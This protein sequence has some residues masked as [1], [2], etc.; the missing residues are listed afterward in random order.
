MVS[1]ITSRVVPRMSLTSALSSCSNRLRSVDFPALG[2]PTIATGNPFLMALPT[3]KESARRV[4]A[5]LISSAMA[6]RRV[7]SANSTSSSLKSSSSSISD[8]NSSRRSRREE[9]MRLK[10]PRIWLTAMRC[11]AFEPLAITSATASACDRSRRPF[12]NARRVNSPPSAA[13]HPLPM[14]SATSCCCTHSEPWHDSS[15]TSSPVNDRGPRNTAAT[16]SSSVSPS[17][18]TMR[19]RCSVWV[20]TALRSAPRHDFITHFTASRPLT[21]TTAIPPTPAGVDTAHIVSSLCWLMSN[22]SI[23]NNH[24]F[25][26]FHFPPRRAAKRRSQTP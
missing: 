7:R 5:V 11:A 21:R 24:K 10:P 13:R 17:V 8:T 20:C 12:I 18:S 9:S 2:S 15:M 16:T 19:P 1:S 14:S 4:T 25:F 22:C 26:L 23:R 6:I 3:A